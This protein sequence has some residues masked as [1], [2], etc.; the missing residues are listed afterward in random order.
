MSASI[1]NRQTNFLGCWAHLT[2]NHDKNLVK[3]QW[4]RFGGFGGRRLAA[5]RA[6]RAGH[7][8]F[9]RRPPGGL[10]KLRAGEGWG[11]ASAS[12]CGPGLQMS[13]VLRVGRGWMWVVVAGFTRR[14]GLHHGCRGRMLTVHHIS[15]SGRVGAWIPTWASSIGLV[16]H[17]LDYAS[18]CIDE[19]VVDLEDCE[20][21]VLGQL[22]LLVLW[23]VRVR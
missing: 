22:F 3:W 8:L 20:T 11:V 4:G 14:P 5:E 18:P 17:W 2:H 19:P 16:N 7:L 9:Q 1:R 13:V 21:S 10:Q 15:H 6:D 23:G 12:N